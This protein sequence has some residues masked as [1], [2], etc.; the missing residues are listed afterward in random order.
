MIDITAP[1]ILGE[2]VEYRAD[3]TALPRTGKIMAIRPPLIYVL[4]RGVS[5]AASAGQLSWPQAS[6]VVIPLRPRR[7]PAH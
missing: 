2:L 5:V 4:I 1:R 6:A 7:A 3:P